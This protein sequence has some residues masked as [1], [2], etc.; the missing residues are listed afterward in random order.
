MEEVATQQRQQQALADFEAG[1]AREAAAVTAAPSA[2]TAAEAEAACAL[3]GGEA[4]VP[5]AIASSCRWALSPQLQ[6]QACDRI[7]RS[8]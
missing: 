3:D 1:R 7:S 4:S 5:M 8:A 6:P 2:A